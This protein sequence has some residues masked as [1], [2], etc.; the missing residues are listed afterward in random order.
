[1]KNGNIIISDVVKGKWSYLG[2]ENRIRQVA[3]LDAGQFG[4][5][6]VH[7]WS[8]QEPGSG[9]KESA[10]RTVRML[11]SNGFIARSDR[12]AGDKVTR[13]Q[14][15]SAAIEAELVYCVKGE[16]VQDFIS[17]LETFP[18]G[19]YKDQVDAAAGGFNKMTGKK[20]V[21][22]GRG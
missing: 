8:E 4:K 21:K 19:R 15:L 20:V 9:G 13:A 18:S 6:K 2:R 12:P 10:E 14:P 7:F 5:S 3:E 11:V 22:I 16:W 17:E 1:M